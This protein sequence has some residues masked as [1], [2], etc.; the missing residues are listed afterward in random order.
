MKTQY[1]AKLVNNPVHKVIG[2]TFL[3]LF[4]LLNPV[5]AKAGNLSSLELAIPLTFTRSAD[6]PSIPDFDGTQL[7]RMNYHTDNHFASLERIPAS[8]I[9]RIQDQYLTIHYGK[10]ETVKAVYEYGAYCIK[11]EQ[12]W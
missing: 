11:Y 8:A 9:E 12:N 10:R 4:I 7:T 2:I 6:R 3:S 5:T 1:A